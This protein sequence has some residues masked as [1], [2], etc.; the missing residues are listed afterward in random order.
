MTSVGLVLLLHAG[1]VWGLFALLNHVRIPVITGPFETTIIE[2]TQVEQEEPPPPPPDFEQPPPDFIP[3]PEIEITTQQTNTTAIQNV[4]SAP[5]VSPKPRAS[6]P[7]PEYPPAS[8][9]L[10][11][12]GKVLLALYVDVD[13]RVKDGK[14]EKSSGYP[15]LDDSALQTALR[16]WRFTPGQAEGKP[17]AMWHKVIVTFRCKEP[18]QP[19]QCG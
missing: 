15:L 6:N 3:P 9:R 19:D 11:E 13:G 10:R 7:R 18:G 14:V 17:V 12:E 4:S 5:R 2:D 16:S 8:Q 1:V